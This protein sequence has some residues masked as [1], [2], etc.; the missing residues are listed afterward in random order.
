[1]T[2]AKNENSRKTIVEQWGN[3]WKAIG[4]TVEKEGIGSRV[5]K[6]QQP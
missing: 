1:L 4:K 3:N 2:I 5:Q 6:E